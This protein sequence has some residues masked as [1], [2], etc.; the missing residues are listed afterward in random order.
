MPS[1]EKQIS[2]LDASTDV[3][4]T[5]IL[6]TKDSNGLDVTMTVQQVLDLADT[7]DLTTLIPTTETSVLTGSDYGL[8]SDA[9][10]SG[11]IKRITFSN[12]ID[13]LGLV[14]AVGSLTSGYYS[15]GGLEFRW[16]QVTSSTDNAETFTFAAPFTTECFGVWV[17]R[18]DPSTGTAISSS[19]KTVTGFDIDRTGSISGTFPVQYIAVGR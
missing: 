12:F 17:N 13:G 2:E 11:E 15:I 1:V 8:F 3:G 16:G 19:G 4:T 9:S 18:D 10:A 5:S 7:V 14:E 6:H